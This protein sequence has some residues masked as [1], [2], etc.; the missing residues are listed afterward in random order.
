[1]KKTGG[2]KSVTS[3]L[4]MLIREIASPNKRQ[5]KEKG[6]RVTLVLNPASGQD[7]PIL[8]TIN[9]AFRD[10]DVDYDIVITKG[11]GDGKRLAQE[12]VRSGVDAVAVYGG[13][14]TVT[15]VASALMDGQVPLG[16]L[17][18][19]TT[20]A[21]A[22]NLGIPT[23]LEQACRLIAQPDHEIRMINLGQANNTIF[24]QMIG[25]GLEAKMIE[26]TDRETKDKLGWLAY[27]LAALQALSDPPNAM[28]HLE[29][30]G[31]H[32][33]V[34]GVTCLVIN[35]DNLNIGA[36]RAIPPMPRNGLLDILVAKKA[37]LAS[38]LSAAATAAGASLNLD[39]I[40]HWQA[41][42]VVVRT[43]TPQLVQSDGDLIGKTP[44]TIQVINR[45]VPV[46]VPKPAEE[47]P[48]SEHPAQQP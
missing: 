34:E 16:V 18:G 24:F 20:N 37:D 31:Q 3:A 10:A 9:T 27:G 2:S 42:N 15:E 38:I 23:D 22:I 33:E 35:I 1:M 43:D 25:V 11:Q 48:A 4:S 45:P 8:K 44:V 26:N 28:Y 32:Q 47:K 30:D 29:L 39:L 36:L 13:D 46:I 7:K 41:H 12:A 19:G 21:I 17:P 5:K 40:P 14:G 6:R